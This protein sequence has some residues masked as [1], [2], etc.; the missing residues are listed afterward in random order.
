MNSMVPG[1]HMGRLLCP[2]T[3]LF[4]Y[5]PGISYFPE[6]WCRHRGPRLLL[7][8]WDPSPRTEKPRSSIVSVSREACHVTLTDAPA[9]YLLARRVDWYSRGADRVLPSAGEGDPHRTLE[10]QAPHPQQKNLA[11]GPTFCAQ[12]PKSGGPRARAPSFPIGY[13]LET[14]ARILT[15][16]TFKEKLSLQA[17]RPFPEGAP[18]KV[19]MFKIYLA[20]RSSDMSVSCPETIFF[21]PKW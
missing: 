11:Q 9:L 1:T 19:S 10:F 7:I 5:F 18:R 6:N 2:K 3:I 20:G 21:L 13:F 15:T 12:G 14:R 8:A 16:P 17:S 4:N